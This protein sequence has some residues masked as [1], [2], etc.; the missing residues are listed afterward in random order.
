MKTNHLSKIYRQ[1]SHDNKTWGI[2]PISLEDLE[3]LRVWRNRYRTSF[4]DDRYIS[5]E[6]HRKWYDSFKTSSAEGLLV[7]SRDEKPRAVIGCKDIGNDTIELFNVICGD[8]TYQRTGMMTKFFQEICK[9]LVELSYIR[10]HVVVKNSNMAAHF[11]YRKQRF[12][13]K[14]VEESN[15]YMSLRLLESGK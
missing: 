6:L 7:C 2:R 9:S 15:T 4:F 10:C 14:R 13:L 8:K 5:K 1:F 12:Q 3:V 11:W